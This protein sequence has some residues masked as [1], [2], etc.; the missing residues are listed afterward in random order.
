MSFNLMLQFLT[1][2]LALLSED[3]WGMG[4]GFSKGPGRKGGRGASNLEII[5]WI[6]TSNSL[7]SILSLPKSSRKFQLRKL[8]ENN[9]N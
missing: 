7:R 9:S 8:S 1:L 6:T 4:L 5:L 3:G 2:N